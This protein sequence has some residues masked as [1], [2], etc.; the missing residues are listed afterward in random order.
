MIRERN[1]TILSQPRFLVI[2]GVRED[3]IYISLLLQVVEYFFDSFIH[4]TER[5]HLQ[6]HEILAAL[7][8][9]LVY[10]GF[11]EVLRPRCPGQECG[12]RG[13]KTKERSAI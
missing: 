2:E 7:Y 11:W 5:F 4:P 3:G 13:T 9:F 6:S 10:N 12:T 8:R 1:C